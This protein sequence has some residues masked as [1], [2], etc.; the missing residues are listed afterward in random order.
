MRPRERTTFTGLWKNV[1]RKNPQHPN[2]FSVDA[3]PGAIL[4]VDWGENRGKIYA[5]AARNCIDK[6]I[7][8]C[9]PQHNRFGDR[10]CSKNRNVRFQLRALL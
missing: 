4:D 3:W 1:D 6:P 5:I 7:Q 8:P 10:G 9:K 2:G